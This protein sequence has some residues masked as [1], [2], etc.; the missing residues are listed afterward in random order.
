M[1]PAC[2]RYLAAATEFSEWID[3]IVHQR[4][5]ACKERDEA[6]SLAEYYRDRY[7]AE[8]ASPNSPN[9]LPWEVEK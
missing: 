3:G 8:I 5:I 6:R 7:E 4:D 9:P 1:N 2:E